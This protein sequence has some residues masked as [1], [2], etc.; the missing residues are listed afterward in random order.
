M[1]EIKLPRTSTTKGPRIVTS[2]IACTTTRENKTTSTH[3]MYMYLLKTPTD[4]SLYKTIQ[5][6]FGKTTTESK[7]IKPFKSKSM[8]LKPSTSL[9]TTATSTDLTTS[10]GTNTDNLLIETPSKKHLTGSSGKTRTKD[11]STIIKKSKSRTRST[12][13]SLI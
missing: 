2:K 11:R 1:N 4:T 9:K 8:L 10:M 12:C 6:R 5:P 7:K 13:T 3:N